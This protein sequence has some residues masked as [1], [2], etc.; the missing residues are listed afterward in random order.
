MGVFTKDAESLKELYTTQLRYMYSTEKQIV[1]GL[2]SMIEAATDPQLKQA[3]QS[4][5]QETRTHVKRVEQALSESMGEV[6]DKKCAVTAALIAAGENVVKQTP[7]GPIR[8]AG[9][10]ASA[11]KIE[12][13]E[14]ASYG[15]AAAWAKNLGFDSQAQ[16]L[17]Q[18]LEEE[19]R[20]DQLLTNIADQANQKATRAA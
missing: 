16:M 1:D 5:Q 19:K 18:T 6:D 7:A 2:S 3:F 17:H 8:D 12:H 15:S 10:I 9:L 11:Q 4:H 20:A 13:F 14:M